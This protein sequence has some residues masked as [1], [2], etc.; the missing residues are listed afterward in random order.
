MNR[1]RF[2]IIHPYTSKKVH[3]VNSEKEGFIECY[4]EYKNSNYINSDLLKIYNMNTKKTHILKIK[5]NK[6]LNVVQN[7]TSN[8]AL[9]NILIA[10]KEIDNKLNK[11]AETNNIKQNDT[12]NNSKNLDIMNTKPEDKLCVIL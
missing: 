5:N 1:L 12:E 2:I 3:V 10:L 11:L 8:L 7:N 9:E 6:P 4:K